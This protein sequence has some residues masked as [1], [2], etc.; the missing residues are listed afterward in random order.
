LIKFVSPFLKIGETMEN[1]KQSG[2][3]AYE[4]LRLKICF[5]GEV[6]AILFSFNNFTVIP[7]KPG[8]EL[9]FSFEI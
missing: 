6:N 4:R 2:T 7:S 5:K 9:F 8:E 3:V 1:L